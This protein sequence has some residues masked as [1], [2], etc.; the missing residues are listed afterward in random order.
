MWWEGRGADPALGLLFDEFG[1]L[2]AGVDPELAVDAPRVGL[3][4]PLGDAQGSFNLDGSRPLREQLQ[5]LSLAG[6]ERVRLAEL[7]AA[8]EQGVA[9]VMRL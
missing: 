4:R 8:R 3:E 7:L 9:G 5:H 2:F 1:E 6:A